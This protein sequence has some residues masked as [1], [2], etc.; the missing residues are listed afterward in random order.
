MPVDANRVQAALLAAVSAGA[1]GTVRVWDVGT[2]RL[3]HTIPRPRKT[4]VQAAFSPDGGTLYAAWSEDGVI[5]AIDPATGRWRELGAYGPGLHRLA[6]KWRQIGESPKDWGFD[7]CCTDPSA[8]GWYWRRTVIRNGETVPLGKGEYCPDVVHEFA[9]DFVRRHHDR[10]FFLYYASHLVHLPME[11]TPDSKPGTTDKHALYADNIA[12][13]WVFVQLG[14]KWYARSRDWKLT[15]GG[16][17]FDMR[18]APFVEKP[19]PADAHDPGA[20]AGREKLQKVLD[21][22]NP[23]AGKVDTPKQ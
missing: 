11:H 10:P 3:L 17:L 20:R 8:A 4:A 9:V 18:D 16:E 22:L 23:A 21:A 15:Q 1:D 7:E 12:Y 13:L 19:V 2:L 5:D 6:G 14:E